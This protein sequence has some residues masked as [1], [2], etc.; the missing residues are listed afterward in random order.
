MLPVGVAQEL[1]SI[2]VPIDMTGA[3]LTVTLIGADVA[4]HPLPS[5]YVTVYD[6]VVVTLI[7]VEVDPVDH[8][9]PIGSED[10][11]VTLPPSQNVVGPPAVIVGVEGKGFTVTF[12][13]AE[14]AEHP[15]P[16]V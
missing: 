12:V 3:G 1:G 5:V 14:V 8:K 9:L 2:T 4:E 15:L 6:P 10:V 7:L 13:G 11:S 16:S